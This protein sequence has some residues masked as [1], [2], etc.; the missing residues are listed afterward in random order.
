L[1]P[2]MKDRGTT[3]AVISAGAVA[4]AAACIGVPLSLDL[5]LAAVAGILA[6]LA[7]TT[8]ERG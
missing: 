4:L 7:A 3:T 1:M 5:P 6:G 2:A 8:G